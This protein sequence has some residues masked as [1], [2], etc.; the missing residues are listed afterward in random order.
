MRKYFFLIAMVLLPFWS[1]C[2]SSTTGTSV[3]GITTVAILSSDV[4]NKTLFMKSRNNNFQLNIINNISETGTLGTVSDPRTGK[5]Q[6]TSAGN[7]EVV[8][9]SGTHTFTCIQ[10]ETLYLLVFDTTTNEISRLYLDPVNAFSFDP[11]KMG[12][13]IQMLSTPLNLTDPTSIN[14]STFAGSLTGVSGL[15]NSTTGTAALFNRPIG[16]TTDGTNFYVTDYLNNVIRKIDNSGVVTTLAG[17]GAAGSS[18]STDGTGN[19]ATF[20]SPDGITFDGIQTLYVTDYA[21]QIIRSVDTVSGVVKT[22]AGIVGVAGSVDSTTG[23][24][25]GFNAPLGITTDGTNL[26]VAD[27]GNQTIRKIVISSHAVSTIAG[28]VGSIGSADGTSTS[29]RFNLPSRI[30]TDGSN[31]YVT[32]FNNRTIRKIVIA[33][34]VVTTPFGTAGE[35]G[36]AVDGIGPA[37]RFYNLGGITTDGSNLYITDYSDAVQNVSSST[38]SSP[39]ISLI[40]KVDLSTGLVSTLAGGPIYTTPETLGADGSN[41]LGGVARFIT[42]IAITTNGSG[43]YVTDGSGNNIR[44]LTAL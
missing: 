43:L 25:A 19:T 27:Y 18:D 16:I 26:Y 41:G 36:G 10:K 40:R 28:N 17:T 37:A 9:A 6:L 22:I 29:A 34:G 33:T 3:S 14:V 5:W 4:L 38:L 21:N 15:L 1:G 12:G 7:I 23:T 20:N 24:S 11:T 30:T 8:D 2:G 35:A 32:D 44:L 13:S 39:F 31:L 42:P